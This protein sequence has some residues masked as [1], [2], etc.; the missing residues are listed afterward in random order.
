LLGQYEREGRD[1]GARNMLLVTLAQEPQMHLGQL[2]E[3]FEVSE[4]YLR[5]LRRKAEAGGLGAGLSG[6]ALTARP[7]PAQDGVRTAA[8]REATRSPGPH[9]GGPASGGRPN[10]SGCPD[11]GGANRSYAP[12]TIL[13]ARS[14]GRWCPGRPSWTIRPGWPTRST[15]W[16]TLR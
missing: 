4:E 13:R 15:R 5:I 14:A 1:R 6:I 12:R 7:A 3:A 11:R 16:P 2:T 10:R 8:D 9:G